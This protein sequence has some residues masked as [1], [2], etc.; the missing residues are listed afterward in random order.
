MERAW[1]AQQIAQFT[2]WS[3][4]SIIDALSALGITR[5][6]KQRLRPPFGWKISPD[7]QFVAHVREQKIVRKIVQLSA[8]G[9]SATRLAKFLNE[10]KV[11]TK[12][13]KRWEHKTIKAILERESRRK[14]ENHD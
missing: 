7:G 5:P 2:G 6:P 11:P 14:E 9:L 4:T 8:K 1:S 10:K 3:K 13:R 12:N